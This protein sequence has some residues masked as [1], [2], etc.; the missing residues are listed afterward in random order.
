MSRHINGGVR[1]T[2]YQ[3]W[4]EDFDSG[5]SIP[6]SLGKRVVLRRSGKVGTL[7][8]TRRELL[9]HQDGDADNEEE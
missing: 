4:H 5:A 8:P 7:K 9:C 3:I 1:K 2:C 6:A